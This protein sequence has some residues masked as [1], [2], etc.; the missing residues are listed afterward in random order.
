MG[1]TAG[2]NEKLVLLGLPGQYRRDYER[3]FNEAGFY[4]FKPEKNRKTREGTEGYWLLSM[5]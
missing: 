3:D 5:E 1:K 2:E 4:Y